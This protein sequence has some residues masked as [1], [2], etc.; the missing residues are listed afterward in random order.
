MLYSFLPFLL[1]SF[2]TSRDILLLLHACL[3]APCMLYSGMA[4]LQV[5]IFFFFSM[6]ALF[7]FFSMHALQLSTVDG[8]ALLER[9]ALLR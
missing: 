7:F 4:L 1:D 8:M 6:H 9:L 3:H 5:E 2:A